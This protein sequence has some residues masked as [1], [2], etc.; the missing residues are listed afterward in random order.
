MNNE[1]PAV[2]ELMLFETESAHRDDEL[3]LR[4]WRLMVV[5]DDEDVHTATLFALD[6]VQILGR[7]LEFLHAY[8]AAEARTLLAAE[9]DVGVI[10]LDV[11]MERD[12]A[13]LTLVRHI[14][15]ELK[16]SE[17]RIIL[18][19][20]QPGYAPEIEA[21]RDYDIN[22]YKTKSELTRAKLFT[23]LTSSMRSYD[24]IRTINAGQRGLDKI[25]RGSAELIA[26]PALPDFAA[27]VVTQ[28]AGLLGLPAEG[29]V[30]AKEPVDAEP[31]EDSRHWVIAASGQFADWRDRPLDALPDQEI[32]Q[33]LL[34]SLQS[35]KNRFER[36]RAILHVGT[37]ADQDLAV[38]L[39]TPGPLSLTDRKL[40]E[41]FCSNISV[42]LDNVRLVT[43]LRKQAYFDALLALPNRA[44]LIEQMD[45]RIAQSGAREL[46]VILVDIDHFAEI[47]DALGHRYGDQLLKAVAER[48][49]QSL[50]PELMLAR[51]AG[52]AFGIFGRRELLQP[53]TVLAM[54]AEPF[55]LEGAH[56][57]LSATLGLANFVDVEGGGVDAL[58][59][60]SIALKR[61]K[62]D[63]RGHFAYF[64]H[65][66]GV[67]IRAR[68][69]LLA[70]LRNAFACDHLFMHYQP[71]V[72]LDDLRLVG[73]EALIRWKTEEGQFVPPDRFIPLAEYSGLIVPIGEWVMRTA[74]V[75]QKIL[76]KAGFGGI[77]MAINVSVVQ[78][79]HPGFLAT[80]DAALEAS[81]ADPTLIELEITESVAMLEADYMVTMLNQLKS[82]GL[83]IAVDDFGTG[84]S[85]LSYLQK[86]AIDRLKID[87][88]FV[89]QMGATGGANS[90]AAMVI[91][92]GR[93]LGLN[94][95]AEG[96]E[97]ESQATRLR[98]MGCHEAQGFLYARPMD[99][100]SLQRW[101][102]QH[103][104]TRGAAQ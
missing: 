56:Q 51:V 46:G 36:H 72:R 97:D 22:D 60:A 98:E 71:Q 101:I 68:V 89:N 65:E 102:R 79:R 87:R 99:D 69:K 100:Q 10:L 96:V 27:G 42:C 94:V 43:R 93:N 25:V 29:L 48:L 3:A 33:L 23:T 90:I 59:A 104:D 21:I 78:F 49:L 40:L 62:Q 66:M 19:T 70:D 53:M 31:G 61:A 13:G 44:H 14:R 11:V 92:L 80:V 47:N 82:R 73:V 55:E 39:E 6:K 18:R 30:C 12:D 17:V 75:Q 81:G 34:D 83:Q 20:G 85:S 16:L 91:D 50:P 41:V 52:D 103:R 77:R 88:S 2:D 28:L 7:G 45:A 8:S 57:T 58:K 32:A 37:A 64:T 9:R 4:P 86:L 5:D 95:I 74:M 54:F 84:F 35:K 24:Q 38:C 63:R 15:E 26:L 76:S 1:D 67:E